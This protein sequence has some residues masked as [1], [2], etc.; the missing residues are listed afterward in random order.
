MEIE[1]KLNIHKTSKD[2]IARRKV[3]SNQEFDDL[4]KDLTSDFQKDLEIQRKVFSKEI[5][6]LEKKFDNF[7][8]WMNEKPERL[9]LI[10]K[11]LGDMQNLSTETL[12]RLAFIIKDLTRID[13]QHNHLEEE[14][15][16]TEFREKHPE[17]F[18]DIE[19]T[20]E[21][22]ERLKKKQKEEIDHYKKTGKPIIEKVKK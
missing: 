10:A 11:N 17:I 8:K 3:R 19:L 5:K 1:E 21:E 16:K 2:E 6:G 22:D 7:A 18:N 20:P 13:T 12:E 15:E 9:T 14:K 4:K